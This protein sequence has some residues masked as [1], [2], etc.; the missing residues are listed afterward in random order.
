MDWPASCPHP[1]QLEPKTCTYSNTHTGQR[2]K[3]TL[4]PRP[5]NHGMFAY[6]PLEDDQDIFVSKFVLE[7]LD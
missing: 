2:F 3:A 5:I 6:A 4:H 7:P 1:D